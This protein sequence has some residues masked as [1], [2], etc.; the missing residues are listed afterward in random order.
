MR[1]FRDAGIIAFFLKKEIKTRIGIAGLRRPG[2]KSEP[3]FRLGVAA[4]PSAHATLKLAAVRLN[5]VDKVA[6]RTAADAPEPSESY[7]SAPVPEL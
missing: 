7:S 4:P 5:P 3:D 1:L 6:N 2:A